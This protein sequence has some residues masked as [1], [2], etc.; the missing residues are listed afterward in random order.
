MY[1]QPEQLPSCLGPMG[2]DTSSIKFVHA[3]DTPV[4]AVTAL[5]MKAS[6]ERIFVAFKVGLN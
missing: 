1:Q 3:K 5:V 6:N 2:V 4:S